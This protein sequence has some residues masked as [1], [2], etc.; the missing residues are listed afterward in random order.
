MVANAK[1]VCI[2]CRRVYKGEGR[3]NVDEKAYPNLKGRPH[4][5]HKH[6]GTGAGKQLPPVTC[7]TC[8]RPT[9]RVSH[10]WRPPRRL[11]IRAWKKIERGDWFTENKK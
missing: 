2:P 5:P 1:S 10:V 3:L 7:P 4:F 9:V 8:N 11:N 6:V